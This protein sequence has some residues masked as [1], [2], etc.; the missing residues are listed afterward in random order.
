MLFA[1][2]HSPSR[3][4]PVWVSAVAG[5]LLS[6][7]LPVLAVSPR[8][9]ASSAHAAM[10]EGQA[11]AT[12]RETG[13][14]LG[15]G[16]LEI[17]PAHI[18]FQ[19][20]YPLWTDGAVKRRWMS[21]PPGGAIDGRDPDAWDFPVGTRF[22]KEFSFGG[23]R[24]ETRYMERLAN[25]GWLFATYA[26]AEDGQSAQLVS[27]KGRSRAFP[28]GNGLFH[29]IPSANDCRACHNASSQPVLGFSA[30]QLP[31]TCDSVE[32]PGATVAGLIAR[33]LLSTPAGAPPERRSDNLPELERA[34]LGYLHGNCGHCHNGAGPLARLG[35]DFRLSATGRTPAALSSAVGQPLKSPPPGL[36]PGTLLRIAPGQPGLSAV[37]QRM[38]SRWPV[39][40]MPPLG[41][42]LSDAEGVALINRWI[43]DMENVSIG[44]GFSEGEY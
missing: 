3:T 5:V 9:E 43:A 25:G 16:S 6:F 41:T 31:Y 1:M 38:A 12:L 42:A 2:S 39:L 30:V 19:P 24:V 21:M 17:D 40:Q 14:F 22:W 28:L 13:L 8:T 34:A 11:P 26:W 33:G 35:L 23:T 36:H 18:A 44:P 27:D 29:A 4:T 7:S 10:R 15:D 32:T 20:Q 37:P